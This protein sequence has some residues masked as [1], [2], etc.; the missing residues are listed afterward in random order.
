MTRDTALVVCSAVAAVTTGWIEFS[1]D[2]VHGDEVAAMLEFPVGALPVAGGRLHFNLVGVAVV[3][4]RAFVA[5]GAESVIGR[6]VE[7]VVFDE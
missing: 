5:G 2:F 7:T 6:G 4:E 1:F 3:A